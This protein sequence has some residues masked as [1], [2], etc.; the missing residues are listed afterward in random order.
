M[1][2]KYPAAQ[3]P[4]SWISKK[5]DFSHMS[6]H[7]NML[8]S[9]QILLIQ[10]RFQYHSITLRESIAMTLSKQDTLNTSTVAKRP[11]WAL[12]SLRK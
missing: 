4:R 7:N 5:A 10:S 9:W 6:Y 1:T 11:A 2:E 12:Y 3:C 8:T